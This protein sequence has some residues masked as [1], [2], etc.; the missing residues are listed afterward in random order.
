MN[1]SST[2]ASVVW[3]KSFLWRTLFYFVTPSET[4]PKSLEETPDLVGQIIPVF[5]VLI[6][7]EAICCQMMSGRFRYGIENYNNPQFN[8]Y[9]F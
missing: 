7:T 3:E 1:S 2:W 4:S 5:F 8:Y 6:V 9:T